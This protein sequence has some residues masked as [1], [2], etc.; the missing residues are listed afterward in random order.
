MKTEIHLF[1]IAFHKSYK[2]TNADSDNIE[3]KLTDFF[4]RA[5]LFEQII[6]KEVQITVRGRQTIDCGS[7]SSE[8]NKGVEGPNLFDHSSMFYYRD[9]S[10]DHFSGNLRQRTSGNLGGT[11]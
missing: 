10:P 3:C 1:D 11:E 2:K 6:S 8:E 7:V 9:I 5:N 4:H